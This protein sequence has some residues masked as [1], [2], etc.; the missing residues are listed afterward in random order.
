[1]RETPTTTTPQEP[2]K[3]PDEALQEELVKSAQITRLGRLE[4]I[5][6]LS[7]NLKAEDENFK[8]EFDRF[9]EY[10]HGESNG[11]NSGEDPLDLTAAGDIHVH[12]G[13]RTDSQKTDT[14][15]N[16]GQQPQDATTKPETEGEQPSNI[17]QIVRGQNDKIDS[18]EAA[19]RR[20]PD[21]SDDIRELTNRINSLQNNKKTNG[22]L[23]Y[24]LAA[25]LGGGLPLAGITGYAVNSLIKPDQIIVQPQENN[26]TQPDTRTRPDATST[27]RFVD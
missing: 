8:K 9:G 19:I 27:I 15:L 26:Q 25:A 11:S 14:D 24:I 2:R 13:D 4:G 10:L 5:K 16:T 17:E 21:A 12:I 22:A 23:P 18:I 6:S 20:F 7:R 3:E 1:M